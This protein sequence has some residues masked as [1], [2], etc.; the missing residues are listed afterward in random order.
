MK[1]LFI[2]AWYPNRYD[3]MAGL[4]V[5]KHAE[6]VSLYCDVRVLYVHADETIEKTEIVD[7]TFPGFTETCVYYPANSNQFLKLFRLL[8]AYQSGFSHISGQGFKPDLIH[9]NILTRTGFVAYLAKKTKGIPFVINEHWSR[10]LPGNKAFNNIFHKYLTQRIVK[11]ASSVLVVSEILKKG[12]IANGLQH[13]NIQIVN[14]VV[15][16]FF[17]N[18]VPGE[19]RTMKRLLHISCFEEKSKN[20]CGILRATAEL[21]KMRNDFELVLIGIGKDFE[22]ARE[23][24]KTLNLE[25]GLVQFTGEKT[26]EEVAEWYRNCDGVVQFSNYETA[27]VVVAESLVSGKPVISSNT[28][29][30]PD[31]INESNGIL[32]EPR[33]EKALLAAMNYL[34]NNLD[35]YDSAKI[36][37]N[38]RE[39]F[40]YKNVGEK[41]IEVYRKT[42]EKTV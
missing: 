8:R 37:E 25:K 36:K 33:D 29:I 21:S 12:M 31:F 18:E 41:I 24:E 9:A 32:V 19:I 27:G 13:P 20:I 15:D 38:A 2:S 39:Y 1:V 3:A 22:M 6:A 26:P 35:K 40:S 11:N 28:G 16:D 34:L 10:F 17:F 23:F 30:A 4:F 14:N 5:R 42:L 7:N